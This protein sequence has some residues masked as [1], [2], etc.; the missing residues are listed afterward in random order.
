MVVGFLETYQELVDS[1]SHQ[2]YLYDSFG[3]Q[4]FDLAVI[5]HVYSCT[6]ITILCCK[7]QYFVVFFTL[8]IYI[9]V[10]DM[11]MLPSIEKCCILYL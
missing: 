3:R 4:N 10:I 7:N 11:Y 5:L 2:M 9:I 1:Y 6:S 8:Y